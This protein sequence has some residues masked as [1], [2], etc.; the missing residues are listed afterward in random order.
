MSETLVLNIL[1]VDDE[2]IIQQTLSGFIREFGH[3]SHSAYDGI[4]AMQMIADQAFDLALIDVRMPGID[5]LALLEK[6]RKKTPSLKVVMITG[7]GDP[8]MSEKAKSLGAHDFITKP[9]RLIDI[10][11]LFDQICAEKT[12]QSTD[13]SK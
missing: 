10:M 11:S 12:T 7:H 3:Q 9:I 5:G 4:T 2:K 1:I 13:V 6:I 8:A